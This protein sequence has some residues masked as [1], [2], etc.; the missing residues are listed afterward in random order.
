[1]GE[2]IVLAGPLKDFENAKKIDEGGIEYWEAR[3]LMLHLGYEEWRNFEEVIKRAINAAIGSAQDPANHFVEINKMVPLG[4]GAVRPVRDYK[5]DRY[6]CYLIA[7]NGDSAKPQIA[8][9]QTYFAFQT[10][11]QEV[12]EKLSEGERRLFIRGEVKT[13]NKKLAGTAKAAG[14][15]NFGMFNNQGYLG[16]YHRTAQR[17]EE[18]KGLKKGELLDRAGATE[19][20]ANLF[21]ITQTDEKIKNLRVKG[22]IPA[23]MVHRDVGERVRQTIK[24]I[25]GEFPEYLPPEK[26]IKEVKKEVRALKKAEIKKTLGKRR[27]A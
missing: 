16:L 24:E 9:A 21:R 22:Q 15:T 14:V 11:K 1:M 8:L 5:L 6:A 25:G 2:D 13:S 7:Q 18:E 12:F 20:A 23:S 26:H 3:E 27:A 4:S 19:L 10:R 17:I